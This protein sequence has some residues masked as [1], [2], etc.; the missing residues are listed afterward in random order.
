MIEFITKGKE[1]YCILDGEKMSTQEVINKMIDNILQ[2]SLQNV[3]KT[4]KR[5]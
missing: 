5:D 1:S 2:T 3:L 4:K